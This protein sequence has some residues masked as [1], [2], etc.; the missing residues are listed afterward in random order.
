MA[1]GART[2]AQDTYH[3]ARGMGQGRKASCLSQ[4]QD[5][6]CRDTAF[7]QGGMALG[8]TQRGSSH[9]GSA[10]TLHGDAAAGAHGRRRGPLRPQSI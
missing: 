3:G 4:V 8:C 5:G 2:A 6:M 9:G 10:R 7:V 1:R